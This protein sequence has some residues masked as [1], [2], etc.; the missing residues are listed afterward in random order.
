MASR[1]FEPSIGAASL[2]LKDLGNA[3]DLAGALGLGLPMVE[4]ALERYRRLEAA[5]GIGRDPSVLVDL[6]Q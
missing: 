1:T 4:R 3:A 6:D 5:G 2:M